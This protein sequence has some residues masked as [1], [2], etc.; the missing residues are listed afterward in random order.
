[1]V[2]RIPKYQSILVFA[3]PLL[4]SNVEPLSCAGLFPRSER[5]SHCLKVMLV[6]MRFHL[7]S[8]C[9]SGGLRL[10]E[11]PRHS[12]NAAAR[13]YYAVAL[14]LS[15]EANEKS[16]VQPGRVLRFQRACK[17]IRKPIQSAHR[18]LI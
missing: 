14:T 6:T 3:S 15:N 9:E 13:D 2:Q 8:I 4:G 1:M 17:E 16:L 10:S 11:Q 12:A 7:P 5:S 18:K